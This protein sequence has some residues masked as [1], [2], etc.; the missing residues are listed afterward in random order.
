MKISTQFRNIRH[1][2]LIVPESAGNNLTIDGV[3]CIPKQY[4]QDLVWNTATLSSAG[5]FL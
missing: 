2:F 3:H 1:P 4:R 5:I